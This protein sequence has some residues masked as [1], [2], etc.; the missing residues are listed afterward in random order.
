[1]V[2]N[3]NEKEAALVEQMRAVTISRQYGTVVGR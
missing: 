1:M 3:E 2:E